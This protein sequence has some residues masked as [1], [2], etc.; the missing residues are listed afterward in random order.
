MIGA[1]RDVKHNI[2]AIGDSITQGCQT[3]F[4][5]YEFW[6]ARISNL[7]GDDYGFYNCGLGWARASD[8]ALDGN[9]LERA[10]SAE[11]VIV[12][13]GTND[14]ISG[15]Y[16]SEK[17]STATEIDEYLRGVLEKLKDAGC[18]IIVFNAPPQDYD[19]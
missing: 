15:K 14:I 19:E 13:F 3:E 7:L 11:T 5:K 17:G 4:M 8:A 1:N 10:K 6:S 2:A 18:K 12:A 16:Q 9:W